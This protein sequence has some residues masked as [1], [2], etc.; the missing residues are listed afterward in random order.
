MTMLISGRAKL[1]Y[2]A[3]AVMIPVMVLLLLPN[4]AKAE[5]CQ[6]FTGDQ[7]GI[8]G[9]GIFLTGDL[10]GIIKF[11][12]DGEVTR[13]DNFLRV[14]GRTSEFTSSDDDKPGTFTDK[15]TI[16][17][18]N[19]AGGTFTGHTIIT[20]GTGFWE[21]VSGE[22]NRK[23]KGFPSANGTYSAVICFP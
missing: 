17:M 4:P 12:R 16:A 13:S 20:G 10:N 11:N 22:L 18:V 19:L 8:P 21:G 3:L 15:V 5:G 6:I 9:D 23:G 1:L 2:A 14:Q 7:I